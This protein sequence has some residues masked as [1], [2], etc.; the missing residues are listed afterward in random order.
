[1]GLIDYFRGG[2]KK[3]TAQLLAE[4]RAL[5]GARKFADAVT[6]F[7]RVPRRD[8]TAAVLAE[9]G[10]AHLGVGNT[11]AAASY[12]GEARRAD[13]KCAEAVCIQGEVLLREGRKYDALDRF[14]EAL[15]L[16]PACE[17]AKQRLAE[18]DLPRKS[19]DRRTVIE[20]KAQ[21]GVERN[22][23]WAR[24]KL[25][26]MSNVAQELGTRG[27]YTDAISRARETVVFAKKHLGDDHLDTA[28]TLSS[29]GDL[30]QTTGDYAGARPYF[31]QALEINRRVLGD[32]HPTTAQSLSWLGLLLLTTGDYAGARPY[33]EQAL[34]INRRVLG[35]DSPDT[36]KSLNNLGAL[37]F[38]AGDHE[39]ARA[40]YEQALEILRRVLGDD[41]SDTA[42]CLSNLGFLLQT[43]GDRA[44]SR[45][46]YE[47]SLEV[48]R[49]LLGNDHPDTA[50]T[51]SS[52]GDLLRDAGDYAA[53]RPYMEQAMEIFQRVFGNDH[54]ETAGSIGAI[55]TLLRAT[56]NPAGARPY[57]EQALMV[58]RQ[59]LGDDHPDVAHS[60]NS[61]GMVNKDLGHYAAARSYL[62][63]ALA[64]RGRVLGE[65]HPDT[66]TSL[67][68]LG[69]LLHEMGD[70][71][72]ARPC[73]EQALEV[74]R[75][76]F[77]DDH[78]ETAICLS[79]L[80]VLLRVAGDHAGARE[81]HK[82]ALDA[83]RRALGNDHPDT[84]KCLCKLGGVLLDAGDYA[85]ARPYFEQTLEINRRVLGN[86]HLD[87]AQSLNNLGILLSAIG[88]D[89]S[90]RM[91]FEQALEVSHRI[92]GNDHPHVARYLHNLGALLVATDCANEGWILLL[93]ATAID[94]IT[95]ARVSSIS[96]EAQRASYR[97]VLQRDLE[98]LLS[99]V[100]R[101]FDHSALKTQ[102]AM[103][104]VF[105]RKGL[106]A[107]ALAVQRDAVLGG[108]YPHLRDR[109]RELSALRAQIS[110]AV[111]AGP[112]T[113][114]GVRLR[115]T[116]WTIQKERL[117][118]ELAREV[119]E[120]NLAQNLRSAGHRAIAVGLDAGVALVE[121]VRFHEFDFHATPARGERQWKSARYL[122]FV[123]LGGDPDTVAMI[124]LGEANPIDRLID[125]F[126][127][128][129]AVAPE[130]RQHRNMV[131]RSKPT[132][133]TGASFGFALRAALL[134]P[135]LPAL[136]GRT[137]LLVSPDGQLARLPFAALPTANGQL[138]AD[139]YQISYVSTGRDALRFATTVPTR[140]EAPLVLCDPDFDLGSVSLSGTTAGR[141]SHDLRSGLGG[142]QRL[143]GTLA[144]GRAVGRLLRVEP[145]HGPEAV[146]RSFLAAC[147]SPR[148]LHLATHGFFLEDQ[149]L[150]L[151]RELWGRMLGDDG[152]LSA[153]VGENPLLRSGLVL[154]GANTFLRGDSTSEDAD[155]G[156]L[157]ALDVTGLDLLGTELVVLSACETGLG[158]VQV[159]EGVIGLQRAFTIAG[160]QTLVMSLWS[161]DDEATRE[162]MV[163]FYRRLL[164]GEGK[165]NAL[166]H[167]QEELRK[168]PEYDHPYYWAAFVLLGDPGPLRKPLRP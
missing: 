137:R 73:F 122:A 29:L 70:F 2:P 100:F 125:A 99:A 35:G 97:K 31:E 28:Q 149:H 55:G 91:Y 111:F 130:Y 13:A 158:D 69:V 47:Q 124:D 153:D 30:L 49:R 165:A 87:T 112:K 56:G 81:Y 41:N 17:S 9:T 58:R 119:P 42:S 151:D 109:M 164:A 129:I 126:R 162:L 37:L 154:A 67:N 95:F 12:A 166:R 38:A 36:A 22:E 18:F 159:G 148:I 114:A 106:G 161:V 19:G 45:V 116:E 89:A 52:L 84:A 152:R 14:R 4:A 25:A 51:L 86:D 94:D 88:D 65:S 53:A 74:C 143:P 43:L 76:S 138:L 140:S 16:D 157:T 23:V 132:A 107:E 10:W 163:E 63:Q 46:C 24:A 34:E 3:T 147:V 72:G 139:Q 39:G 78:S 117:E 83:C 26:E 68:N 150:D 82:Q 96:S 85:E 79:N 133:D 66:S 27:K 61:L 136:G 155:N 75:R 104:A 44:E 108:R 60:L 15:A 33:F 160:A 71:A 110:R 123:L 167:A 98:I 102:A 40:Q 48:H 146:K 80:G 168:K 115:L 62:E 156:L 101:H 141:I 1:M 8:R 90:A 54:P 120:M 5:V 127:A 121:F 134:D 6:V 92:L 135:L 144:E 145:R 50:R 118:S 103:D 105:R 21:P 64:V 131:Q 20:P 32:D 59:V 57:L 11:M 93:Q 77:G 113:D 7:E 128:S 142:L